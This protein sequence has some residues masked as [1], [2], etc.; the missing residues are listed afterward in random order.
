MQ[1]VPQARAQVPTES[2]A[3]LD[4]ALRDAEDFGHRAGA[5]EHPLIG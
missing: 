3:P 1:A 5:L 4:G 2:W